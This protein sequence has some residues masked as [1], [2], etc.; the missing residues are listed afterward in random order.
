M[1]I[2]PAL[3]VPLSPERKVNRMGLSSEASDCRALQSQYQ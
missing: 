3:I 1:S 2:A